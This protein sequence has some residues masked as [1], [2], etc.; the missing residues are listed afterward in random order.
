MAGTRFPFKR[1]PEELRE[2]FAFPSCCMYTGS[3]GLGRLRLVTPSDELDSGCGDRS[4]WP[5]L[6]SS[7]VLGLP[8][9][10]LQRK[11][12][13]AMFHDSDRIIGF[14]PKGNTRGGTRGPENKGLFLNCV[15]FRK[16]APSPRG[17]TEGLSFSTSKELCGIAGLPTPPLSGTV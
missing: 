12:G 13:N 10:S 8:S 4:S 14:Q 17:K 15:L 5:L 11:R 2:I 6:D 7:S 9:D 1:T 3:M 16:Q